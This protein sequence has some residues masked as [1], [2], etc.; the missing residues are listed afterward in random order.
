MAVARLSVGQVLGCASA[1]AKMLR[2]SCGGFALPAFVWQLLREVFT[3]QGCLVSGA[4]G[5]LNIVGSEEV[6]KG[7]R[8]SAAT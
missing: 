5:A 4:C 1:A 6:A 3:L 2:Q 7:A 8:G